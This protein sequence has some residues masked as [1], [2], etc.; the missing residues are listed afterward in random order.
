[1]YGFLYTETNSQTFLN[2]KRDQQMMSWVHNIARLGLGATALYGFAHS[3]QHATTL[4]FLRVE[5]SFILYQ[6][7]PQDT[8]TAFFDQGTCAP[9]IEYKVWGHNQD[10][11]YARISISGDSVD[12]VGSV[13]GISIPDGIVVLDGIGKEVPALPDLENTLQAAG[14]ICRSKDKTP[15]SSPI[16]YRLTAVSSRISPQ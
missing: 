5:K 11:L 16:D 7:P 8:I 12:H 3:A 6:Q 2:S 10:S 9:K 1:M 4:E 15:P 14:K 13:I